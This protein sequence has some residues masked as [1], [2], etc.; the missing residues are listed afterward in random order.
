PRKW[1]LPGPELQGLALVGREA[2]NPP[3]RQPLFGPDPES[4]PLV[5]GRPWDLRRMSR[6]TMTMI[7]TPPTESSTIIGVDMPESLPAV[8]PS[9]LRAPLSVPGSSTTPPPSPAFVD[10]SEE[11]LTS[12]PAPSESLIVNA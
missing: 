7:A 1:M 10:Y 9:S 8:S 5:P 4:S 6:T 3:A 11:Y 2:Q 12:P